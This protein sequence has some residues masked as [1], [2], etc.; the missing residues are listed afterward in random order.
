[1]RET[2]VL[3]TGD[4]TGKKCNVH[5][6]LKVFKKDKKLFKKGR[7]YPYILCYEVGVGSLFNP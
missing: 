6:T 4:V 2:H 3:L 1:M 7:D 5:G